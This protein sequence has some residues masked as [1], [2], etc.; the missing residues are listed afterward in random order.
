[1]PRRRNSSFSLPS[2]L[3]LASVAVLLLHLS[4]SW[5]FPQT[6]AFHS[7]NS[8]PS[9]QVRSKSSLHK[10][11]AHT[12]RDTWQYV[13]TEYEHVSCTNISFL[14]SYWQCG[15]RSWL[16]KLFCARQQ[17]RF[18]WGLALVLR[19]STSACPAKH[20]LFLFSSIALINV[21]TFL[22]RSRFLFKPT[23]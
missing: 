18:A 14:A 11:M 8:I 4:T 17:M 15:L 13:S 5:Q 1:V 19:P 16:S 10:Q 3:F 22:S 21:D 7:R 6:S 9:V 20:A 2:S 23:W 12:A